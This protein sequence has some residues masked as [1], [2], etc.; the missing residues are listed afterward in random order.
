MSHF[1]ARAVA[2]VLFLAVVSGCSGSKEKEIPAYFS[3]Q[4][5]PALK[6]PADL[7]KPYRAQE[8]QLPEDASRVQLPAGMDVEELLKPPR[9]VDDTASWAGERSEKRL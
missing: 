2:P 3:A 4:T 9:I 1:F 7:D 6:V 5:I 8:M